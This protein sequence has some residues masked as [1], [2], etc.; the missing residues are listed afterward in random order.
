MN[1]MLTGYFTSR[2][3]ETVSCTY[4]SVGAYMIGWIVYM[5]SRVM[6]YLK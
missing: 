2:S 4:G 6:Y 3:L 5:V 1:V